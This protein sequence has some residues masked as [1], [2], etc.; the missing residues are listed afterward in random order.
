MWLCLAVSALV[1]PTRVDGSNSR[2]EILDEIR[3]QRKKGLEAALFHDDKVDIDNKMRTATLERRKSHPHLSTRTTR[4][5]KTANVKNNKHSRCDPDVG[6]FS[7]AGA[8]QR[9]VKSR[10][11]SL[12]GFCERYAKELHRDLRDGAICLN[13]E[14]HVEQYPLLE[15]V[16][17]DFNGMAGNYTCTRGPYD[18]GTYYESVLV[19]SDGSYVSTICYKDTA[20]SVPVE[21]SSW[22]ITLANNATNKGNVELV[23]RAKC[24]LHVSNVQ[25]NSCAIAD[26]LTLT[27]H[28][29]N[30]I[31]QH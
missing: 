20:D 28:L 14:E 25:C 8:A 7:C 3:R 2:V 27:C 5:I 10:E 1:H 17:E 31:A 16:C 21:E 9:C 30:S 29:L 11:S 4:R 26:C 24:E 15:C 12:G 22:C 6:I 18:S 13:L 23:K 19:N